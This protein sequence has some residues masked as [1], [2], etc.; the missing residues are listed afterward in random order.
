M[1]KFTKT[2]E[3][4]IS[5]MNS[6]EEET[7]QKSKVGGIV[8]IIICLLLSLVAWVYVAETDDAEVEKEYKN[9]KVVV[10]D[11][12]EQLNIIADDVSVTLVG[13]NSQLVDVNPADIIVTVN[14]LSDRHGDDMDYYVV[15]N[16][17]RYEGTAGVKVKE[18]EVNVHITIKENV[19][20]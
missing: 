16:S 5:N 7:P 13:T 8:A 2:T 12:D 4:E 3:V 15:S 19:E 10:L 11:A 20:K 18:K 17:V 14:A 9:V 6:V 1:D